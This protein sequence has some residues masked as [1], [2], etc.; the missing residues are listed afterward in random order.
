MHQNP[1]FSSYSTLELRS[2]QA[3]AKPFETLQKMRIFRIS[4][5][6]CGKNAEKKR[7]DSARFR[8][9]IHMTSGFVLAN[10]QP[11]LE[12]ADEC[13]NRLTATMETCENS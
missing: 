10:G 5:K 11:V 3:R 4:W 2:L 8:P 12:N 13:G 1:L 9:K 7:H 6:E